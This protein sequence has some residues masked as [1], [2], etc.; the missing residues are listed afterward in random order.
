[1]PLTIRNWILLA[2]PLFLPLPHL[3]GDVIVERAP[4]PELIGSSWFN[5]PNNKPIT[6]ASRKGHVTIVEFWTFSCIN[7]RRNLA[8]YAKW[9]RDL[10][11][12]G[13]EVIG[14]HTPETEPESVKE[15]VEREIARLG[16]RYPILLDSDHENWNRWHQEFWPTVYVIDKKGA[17]RYRWEG[18]LEYNHGGG[19]DKIL[20]LVQHL[21]AE[22]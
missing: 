19:T 12:E 20:E 18:E 4:A 1:M 9:S 21:I 5:T 10:A 17:I 6:L 11:A 15:N 13:V 7:C 2:F 22:P 14:I 3:S 16:I 8:S